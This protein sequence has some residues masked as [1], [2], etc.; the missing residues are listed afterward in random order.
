M[1]VLYCP[2]CGFASPDATGEGRFACAA[3]L[4]TFVIRGIP[5]TPARESEESPE[6][7]SE[8]LALLLFDFMSIDTF[9]TKGGA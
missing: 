7:S 4:T 5:A 9:N 2:V 1:Y 6:F 8:A 3:C